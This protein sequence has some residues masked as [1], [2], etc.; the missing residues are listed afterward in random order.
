MV[1]SRKHTTQLLAMVEAKEASFTRPP[2]R[3]TCSLHHGEELKL[4]CH[5]CNVALCRECAISTHRR[6]NYE[7]LKD[8]A[9]EINEHLPKLRKILKKRRKE[10]KIRLLEGKLL[11]SGEAA[12]NKSCDKIIEIV[13]NR[14]QNLLEEWKQLVATANSGSRKEIHEQELSKLSRPCHIP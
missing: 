10:L 5:D 6:H 13:E 8:V 2:R 4:Y 11:A 3:P 14:R 9:A 12:I 7:Y 1:A